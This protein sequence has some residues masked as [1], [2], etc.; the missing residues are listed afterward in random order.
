MRRLIPAVVPHQNCKVWQETDQKTGKT[1]DD[2]PLS[3]PLETASEGEAKLVLANLSFEHRMPLSQ[4]QGENP[5]RPG[6]EAD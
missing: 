1:A 5:L 2:P 3:V 4:R 6:V